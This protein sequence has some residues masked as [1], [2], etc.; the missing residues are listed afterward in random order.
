MYLA[1]LKKT[2]LR[3]FIF[4]N[5]FIILIIISCKKDDNSITVRDVAD[6]ALLDDNTLINYLETHFYNY[7]EFNKNDG[8]E[9]LEITIDSIYDQ[10]I[11]MEPLFNQV[12]KI[13][14][15]CH[16]ISPYCVH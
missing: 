6:Q 10:N 3:K 4:Y 11:D 7:E 8:F 9:N 2:F 14:V 13:N 1:A 5:L 16:L 12:F 15:L